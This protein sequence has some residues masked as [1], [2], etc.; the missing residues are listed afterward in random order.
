[1]G[2]NQV[3]GKEKEKEEEKNQRVQF[4]IGGMDTGRSER[5]EGS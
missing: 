1:M 5:K 4:N 3:E 2:M